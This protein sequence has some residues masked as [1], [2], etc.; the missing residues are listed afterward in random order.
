MAR[1]AES[2]QEARAL[3]SMDRHARAATN[4]QSEVPSIRASEASPDKE[5]KPAR[6]ARA[7]RKGE[8]ESL[9]S[10][11]HCGGLDRSEHGPSRAWGGNP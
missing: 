5:G 4:W 9:P 1:L 6:R 7:Q 8:A 2:G 3:L 11:S 10:A